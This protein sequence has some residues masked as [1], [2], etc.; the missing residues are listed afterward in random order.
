MTSS[1]FLMNSV[2]YDSSC[3]QSLIF[4]KTRFL[5]DLI[6]SNVQ[7][8]ISDDHMQIKKY[9]IRRIWEQLKGKKIE[10]TFKET[11]YIFICSVILVSQNKLEKEK[12]DRDSHTKTLIHLKTDMQVCEIQR[13]FG[14]QLLEYTL[15]SR[16]QMM[17]NSIQ[18]SRSIMIKATSWQW[19]QRLEH[20]RSQMIDHLSKEW[21][22]SDNAT[23]KTIKC[24][25]CAVFKMHR[26]VQKASSAKVIKLYEML[27]FDLIIYEM[28]DFDDTIC[29]AHFTN[30]F[31]HYS[32]V[33][34]LNDHREKILLSIFKRL[35]NRYDRSSIIINSMMRIIRSNQKTSIDK[36]LEN[37]IINQRIIWDW[38]AKNILEQNDISKRYEALLIE[39]AKCI[40]EHAKL[41]KDLFFECYLTVEHLMNRIFNQTLNWKSLLICMQKL[42]NQSIRLEIEHL[43][44]YE[45]KAYLLLKEANVSSRD[46]KLKSRAF[47]D[48]LIDYN[49]TNIFRIWNSEKDDVS[50]YRD[51]IFDESE[52][53]DIYNK[54]DQI[55]TSEKKSQIELQKKTAKISVD[56]AIEL[57][58]ENDEWLKISIRNR[59][60]LE[61]KRLVRSVRSKSSDQKAIDQQS[62]DDLIQLFI[63]FKISD[64]KIDSSVEYSSLSKSSSLTDVF[65]SSSSS[66]QKRSFDKRSLKRQSS[67]VDQ[68]IKE[69][70]IAMN[71]ANWIEK[72]ERRR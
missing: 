67:D 25:I 32:W 52:L 51:V 17:T 19:H 4:D 34:S 37:R 56:Q 12:F 5:N 8:K 72:M 35:I 46:S 54:N 48:Y 18:S 28:R 65:D 40:R 1:H 59:L 64:S 43:K 23:S 39:K 13:R 47:V 44:M 22:I 33:F 42:I 7:I 11:T 27:H 36:H 71:L 21:I 10:M 9:E 55:I 24:Q 15:I 41:S 3:S 29:I 62:V 68:S 16:N 6:S 53:Y 63:D 49:S 30:K 61:N 2:I 45:C 14:M 57:N 70:I 58:S 66:S 38:S 20:C 69:E 60:I 26:L 50:D 31:T